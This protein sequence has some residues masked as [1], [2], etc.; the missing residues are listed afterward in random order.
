MVDEHKQKL[1]DLLDQAC[2]EQSSDISAK[3]RTTST[4]RDS[5]SQVSA[6]L[7]HLGRLGRADEIVTSYSSIVDFYRHLVNTTTSSTGKDGDPSNGQAADGKPTTPAGSR[8]QLDTGD[9]ETVDRTTAGAESPALTT[10]LACVFTA[11]PCTETNIGILLG[12]LDLHKVPLNAKD[13]PRV[14]IS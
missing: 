9:T 10:R 13:N 3:I 8:D 14:S 6:F 5:L 2:A 4:A 7:L 1:L 11:G 12:P